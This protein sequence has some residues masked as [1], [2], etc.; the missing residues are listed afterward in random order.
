MVRPSGP[1]VTC[2]P[3]ILPARLMPSIT[4][5]EDLSLGKLDQPKRKYLW[6]LY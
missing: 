1:L 5:L 4:R 6:I 2:G 3:K